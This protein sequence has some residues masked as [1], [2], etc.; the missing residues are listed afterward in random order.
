LIELYKI[1]MKK[2]LYPI[3]V[4]LL[5]FVT[6]VTFSQSFNGGLIAG[7]TF[8]QVDGDHYAGYHHIGATAGGYINLPLKNRFSLQ[9]ELKYTLLG[10]HSDLIEEVQ[11]NYNHFYLHFH[12]AE[13]PIMLRYNLGNFIIS[14]KSLDFIALELGV[15]LDFL[16]K[17][18]ESADYEPAYESTRWNFLSMT[19]NAGV[20]IKLTKHWGIEG[21]FMYSIVPIRFTG[22]PGWFNNQYYNKV[23]MATVTYNINAPIR[24]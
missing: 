1:T 23:I 11:Y 9:T 8:S 16:L 20:H 19:G 6:K 14:G 7:A 5:F 18:K 21:R 4:F 10:A 22:H 17:S 13:L 24:K 12:Y 2:A 15:S 3:L